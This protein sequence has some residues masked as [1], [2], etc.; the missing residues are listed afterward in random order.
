MDI[1]RRVCVLVFQQIQRMR[2]VQ[3]GGSHVLRKQHSGRDFEARIH[4]VADTAATAGGQAGD[5]AE[6]VKTAVSE[7][8]TALARRTPVKG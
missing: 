5:E 7:K 2:L 6:I 4:L 3:S 8:E 1:Q